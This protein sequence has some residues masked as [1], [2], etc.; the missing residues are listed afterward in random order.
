MKKHLRLAG[1]FIIIVGIAIMIDSY[2]ELKLGNFHHPDSGFLPFWYGLGLVIFSTA[3]VINNLGS[4]VKPMPFWQKR[5]WLKPLVA[6]LIVMVYSVVMEGIGYILSTFLFL[7]AWQAILEREKWL[8]TLSISVI[9]TIAM[10]LIFEHM[11]GVPL[12]AG[13]LSL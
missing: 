6:A 1:I 3:L 11:L 7:L 8:K 2:T 12:P 9:G 4:D 5:Q 13:I 10:Y